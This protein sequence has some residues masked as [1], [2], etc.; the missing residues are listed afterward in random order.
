M[1][2]TIKQVEE[3]VSVLTTEQQ[4]LLKDTIKYG[5]WGDASYEFLTEK[6]EIESVSMFG[7]CT[8]DAKMAGN[9]SG[10]KISAMF[11]S[12][13]KKLCPANNNQIGRYISHCRD[14]WEDGSGDMLFIRTGYYQAFEEWAKES[15]SPEDKTIR[16]IMDWIDG[17]TAYLSTRTEYARGYKDGIEQAK[18]IVRNIISN[19]P[20]K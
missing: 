12:I 14:W 9:F 10:R 3:I 20:T 16:D 18:E 6:G 1:E 8:N 11:R 13:Y 17:S 19:N 2:I 4:Q 7:Y 5:S 15:V